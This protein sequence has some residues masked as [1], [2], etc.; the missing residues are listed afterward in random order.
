M[1]RRNGLI[2][3]LL[4]LGSD[5]RGWV[6][7]RVFE[8]GLTSYDLVLYVFPNNGGAQ[9]GERSDVWRVAAGIRCV[10]A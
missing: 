8:L 6:F 5:V 10:R 9:C 3:F 7:K 1:V 2:E 4:G